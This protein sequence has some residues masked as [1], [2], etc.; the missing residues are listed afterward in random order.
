MNE[1]KNVLCPICSVELSDCYAKNS[2]DRRGVLLEGKCLT[3]GTIQV[4]YKDGKIYTLSGEKP[5]QY[6]PKPKKEKEE[7]E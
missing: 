4:R 2:M 5:Y 1:I 3:H 7:P 6:P